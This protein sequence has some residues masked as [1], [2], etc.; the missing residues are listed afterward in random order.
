MKK[1]EMNSLVAGNKIQSLK[2]GEVLEVVGMDAEA[3]KYILSNGKVYAGSTI[4]RWFDLYVEPVTEDNTDTEEQEDTDTIAP[5]FN[6]GDK[7]VT[8]FGV[9]EVVSVPHLV[10]LDGK[11]TMSNYRVAIYEDGQRYLFDYKEEQLEAYTE[12]TKQTTNSTGKTNTA[13]TNTTTPATTKGTIQQNNLIQSLNN[14]V[15]LHGCYLEP[16]KEYIAVKK[17]GHRGTVCM[18]MNCRYGAGIH[19]D[20]KSKVMAALDENYRGMLIEKYNCR[21]YDKTRGYYRIFDCMDVQVLEAIILT[22][23]QLSK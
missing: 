19:I 11:V 8:N 3:G 16:K 21:I 20:M 2:T 23:L 5:K 4:Q 12:D 22:G 7:V 15:D 14:L 9:G 10:E 1:Q 13:T 18:I 17:D 6:L